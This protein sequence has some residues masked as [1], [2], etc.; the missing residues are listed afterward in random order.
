MSGLSKFS[1]Q[2]SGVG[3][4]QKPLKPFIASFKMLI[5][6][7]LNCLLFT[8][9]TAFADEYHYNNI[10]I[11]DRAA[12]MAGAYTAISDDPSGLYYNPAGIVF[13]PGRS[14][15]ASVNAYQYSKKTY[16]DVLSGNGWDR[17]SSNLLPNYFGVIQPLGAGKIGF[18][19]AVPDTRQENQAQTFYNLPGVD[20]ATGQAITITRYV[21]NM[22]DTDYTYNFGPSYALKINDKLS[23]G[24]TAYMQY[25]DRQLI[26]NHFVAV[27]N[28]L[29]VAGDER[30]QWR[31]IYNSTSEWGVKPTIG[32]MWTPTEKVSLGFTGSKSLMFESRRR[33]Q[34][35]LRDLDYG[36]NL[37]AYAVWESKDNREFPLTG[38]FGAAY[39]PSESLLLSADVSYYTAAS[40]TLNFKNGGATAALYTPQ[41]ETVNAAVGA[42]YYPS[43]TIAL[44]SGLFTNMANTP[45]LT[46]GNANE[47]EHIDMYGASL[48]I[49]HFTR[50]SS[51][52]FGGSYSYGTGKSHIYGDTSIQNVEMQNI[53]AFLSAAFS[54]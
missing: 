15:S 19:Y 38:T 41:S 13:A 52:T 36:S 47:P 44:R 28:D 6:L 35:T 49:S 30:Y 16:K 34:N 53:T 40:Y 29:S 18:S 39:F 25:R 1:G 27:D 43:A 42:E 48:S 54:Y 4:R 31:N 3:G 32:V 20:P 11:G 23:V 17:V 33:I 10:L 24:A 12:G 2:R 45:N 26:S 22:N 8:A 9:I 21:I 37:P 14:F 51:L 5:L 7:T 46:T 50:S